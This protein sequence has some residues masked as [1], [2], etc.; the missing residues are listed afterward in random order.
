[1]PCLDQAGDQ[2][3]GLATQQPVLAL[4][5]DVRLIRQA[6][7][8]TMGVKA[9]GRVGSYLRCMAMLEAG[10]NRIGLSLEQAR[11]IL[12]GRDAHHGTPHGSR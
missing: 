5:E 3:A 8:P 10:A 6:V 7:G 4:Y 12:N 2:L 9:S 1:M 11:A